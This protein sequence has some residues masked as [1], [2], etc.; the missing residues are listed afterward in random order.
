MW[1]LYRRVTVGVDNNA[2]IS[3]ASQGVPF[4]RDSVFKLSAD[5]AELKKHDNNNLAGLVFAKRTFIYLSSFG[6]SHSFS[7]CEI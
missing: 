6:V 4:L 3:A 7:Y 5:T 1:L 2:G